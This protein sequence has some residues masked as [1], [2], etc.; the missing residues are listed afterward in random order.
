M[1]RQRPGTVFAKIGEIAESEL[2]VWND[3]PVVLRVDRDFAGALLDSDTDVKLVP[4]WLQRM[5]FESLA[6]SFSEPIVVF[7][8]ETVCRYT[9]FIATGISSRSAGFRRGGREG[10]W[11]TY[12]S[13]A[14]SEGVRCLWT[15]TNP[16]DTTPRGQTVSCMVAG[17]MGHD[18][19]LAELVEAQRELLEAEG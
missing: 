17:E 14:R 12:G 15:Y 11:T 1:G 9:G 2:D 19:T 5:P 6:F 8:G 3:S 18:M 13:F 10:S 7:D 16:D 4:S